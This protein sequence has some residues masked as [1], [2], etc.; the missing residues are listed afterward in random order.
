MQ[1]SKG[2]RKI[3]KKKSEK[4]IKFLSRTNGGIPSTLSK[5]VLRQMTVDTLSLCH[6]VQ[7]GKTGGYPE[8]A[9]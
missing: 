3:K 7:M 6:S 9:L 4:E 8:L 5:L 2:N 1:E